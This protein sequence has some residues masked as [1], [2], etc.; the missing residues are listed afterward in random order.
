MQAMASTA[1]VR[2]GTADGARC[3]RTPGL[4]CCHPTVFTTMSARLS[5]TF[6]HPQAAGLALD[7][8]LA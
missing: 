8:G 2:Q 5:L 4:H 1:G 6:A 3:R 7:C